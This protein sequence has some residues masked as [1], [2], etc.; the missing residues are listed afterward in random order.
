M[1]AANIPQNVVIPITLRLSAPAPEANSSGSTP[2]IK[3]HAVISTARTSPCGIVEAISM[4]LPPMAEMDKSGVVRL[5]QSSNV[6]MTCAG[7][8]GKTGYGNYFSYAFDFLNF[9]AE[10]QH[11]IVR[12]RQCCPRRKFNFTHHPPFIFIRQKTAVEVPRNK[13]GRS[14]SY[15]VQEWNYDN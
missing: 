2:K 3:L 1:V 12:A 6:T 14:Q 5:L 4:I 11:G 7:H 13:I 8:N 9:F 15:D 10:F